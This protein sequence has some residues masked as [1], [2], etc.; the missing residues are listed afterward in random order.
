MRV[1]RLGFE[2]VHPPA[3]SSTATCF[4]AVS[5]LDLL[6]GL[7]DSL[8]TLHVPFFTSTPHTSL[9]TSQ[10]DFC[11][12]SSRE[13]MRCSS[14]VRS[15]VQPLPARVELSRSPA[16]NGS[17]QQLS[18]RSRPRQL[19]TVRPQNTA[20]SSTRAR[21]T[22][23]IGASQR[24]PVLPPPTAASNGSVQQRPDTAVVA[25]TAT[26]AAATRCSRVSNSAVFDWSAPLLPPP[27]AVWRVAH[28]SGLFA[29]KSNFGSLLA[30][31]ADDERPSGGCYS[32]TSYLARPTEPFPSVFNVAI[33]L[34]GS[35]AAVYIVDAL[36]QH[37]LQVS[38]G[39]LLAWKDGEKREKRKQSKA[40]S[41][42]PRR[43]KGAAER[44]NGDGSEESSDRNSDEHQA[45]AADQQVT[46]SRPL[47]SLRPALQLVDE[48]EM[49]AGLTFHSLSA[50]PANP[51]SMLFYFYEPTTRRFLSAKKDSRV[52]VRVSRKT[53]NEQWRLLPLT[54]LGFH[55]LAHAA[56]AQQQWTETRDRLTSEQRVAEASRAYISQ[57][58]EQLVIGRDRL[59][60]WR[61]ET[62][63]ESRSSYASCSGEHANKLLTL[64][65]DHTQRTVRVDSDNKL[66]NSSSIAVKRFSAS[67]LKKRLMP[68]AL[69][70]RVGQQLKQRARRAEVEEGATESEA[71]TVEWETAGSRRHSMSWNPLADV[72]SNNTTLQRTWRQHSALSLEPLN[73]HNEQGDRNEHNGE[74]ATSPTSP[75]PVLSSSSSYPNLPA[76][77]VSPAAAARSVRPPHSSS[78]PSPATS[79][80]LLP[81]RSA[82]ARP[83]LLPRSAA[84]Q[85]AIRGGEVAY[86]SAA[87]G[88]RG[89]KR[90]RKLTCGEEEQV[91]QDNE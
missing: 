18:N 37:R 11:R 10:P 34:S 70:W 30:Y 64:H 17:P 76:L 38:G 16:L 54:E 32:L 19:L 48:S 36:R 74:R 52:T 51:P 40:L 78:R 60:E 80:L 67:G 14:S 84:V 28:R 82:I 65:F 46:S 26:S 3:S 1:R 90:L 13:A 75:P 5:A 33:S 81:P 12:L 57:W 62:R 2:S 27:S 72:A 89:R 83:S 61:S 44:D 29:I 79:S 15:S 86:Q 8:L 20:L 77:A 91:Q 58:P 4:L 22:S 35:V 47:E 45:A 71:R 25:V 7:A 23:T 9:P 87:V 41:S 53:S 39:R 68:A 66:D 73:R 31:S 55:S 56:A 59:A 43:K 49:S 50:E 69:Q 63:C 6:F 42:A 85:L 88:V 21:P 24:S